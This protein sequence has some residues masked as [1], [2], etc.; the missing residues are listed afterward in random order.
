MKKTDG[1]IDDYIKNSAEFAQPI[2]T[3]LRELINEACPEIEETM[4]WSFPHFDY[5]GNVCG[6]A[7]FK[8]RCT[9]GFWKASLMA[10]PHELLINSPEAMGHF[11]KITSLADLPTDD[12]LI[13]YIKQA[14]RLNEEGI[15]I[16]SKPKTAV[17]KELNIP[18]YFTGALKENQKASETFE[19][20]SYPHKKEYVEWITEAKTNE[21]RNKRL[22]T[23]IEWLAEGKSRN[24][25]YAK[26]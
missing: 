20:F 16:P 18:A 15:K 12:V 8:Q 14:V 4:K 6:M 19:K 25:K 1:R 9:F 10:D 21:T 11:G 5:K 24:W 3:H 23:A 26:K 17:K 7:A 2:L 22:A 13:E